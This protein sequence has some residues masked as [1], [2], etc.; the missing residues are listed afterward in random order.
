V[1]R[2]IEQGE[3]LFRAARQIHLIAEVCQRPLRREAGRVI[4]NDQQDALQAGGRGLGC[5]L[6]LGIQFS[7]ITILPGAL[8]IS[9]QYQDNYR[10][11][12]DTERRILI[13]QQPQQVV[14]P[15]I[16]TPA[17]RAWARFAGRASVLASPNRLCAPRPAPQPVAAFP[18]T[19]HVMVLT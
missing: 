4:M 5:F 11:R 17:C 9:T 13:L 8:S 2:R 10:Q 16:S 1:E 14:C 12:W 19:T 15:K 6:G 18:A 7:S 3:R